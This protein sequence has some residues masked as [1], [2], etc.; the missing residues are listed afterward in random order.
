MGLLGV[1]KEEA[2]GELIRTQRRLARVAA[3][4]E[5]VTAGVDK[6]RR[7]IRRWVGCQLQLRRIP[8]IGFNYVL[9]RLRHEG[10][11]SECEAMLERNTIKWVQG[12]TTQGGLLVEGGGARKKATAT[13]ECS[14]KEVPHWRGTLHAVGSAGLDSMHLK[15]AH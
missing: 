11:V 5:Q 8:A 15:F 4:R 3:R 2:L 10:R 1:R 7:A 6:E 14:C 9:A 13:W 12:E